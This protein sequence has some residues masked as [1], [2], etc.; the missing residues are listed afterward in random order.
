MVGRAH[1]ALTTRSATSH[2][3]LGEPPARIDPTGDE[4]DGDD[5]DVDFDAGD[6]SGM[7][8][9]IQLS[10]RRIGRSQS[11]LP[12]ARAAEPPPRRPGG[13]LASAESAR[14]AILR[15]QDRERLKLAASA[16]KAIEEALRAQRERLKR[17][18]CVKAVCPNPYRRARRSVE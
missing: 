15:A 12:A 18:K 10:S 1:R 7:G 16:P 11:P 13:H 17:R 8:A 14:K 5:D 3:R 2:R 9:G 6:G 4:T